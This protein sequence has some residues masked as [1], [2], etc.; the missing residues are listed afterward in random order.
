[1]TKKLAI[2]LL[3][4]LAPLAATPAE[5]GSFALFGS[6]WDTEELAE[7]AGAGARLGF[8]FPG[9]FARFELRGSYFPDLTEEFATVIEDRR[10]SG[11]FEI[12][13]IPLE[14]GIS[15]NFGGEGVNPYLG[16]GAS[17]FRLDSN[18]G[19]ISDEV[20]YY[21]VAGL[22]F[23]RQGGGIGFFVE[24][25]Y[26]SIEGTVEVDPEDFEEIPDIEVVQEVDLDLSGF[27]V[28]AGFVWRW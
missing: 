18:I 3:A 17:Y 7:S 13:A 2:L 11:D 23:G 26:R 28:N 22:E 19:E 4:V 12:E 10:V 15:L 21:G 25:I 16:A 5:A 8:S 6:Y 1:M 9:D 20:G 24:A 27:G 14:A